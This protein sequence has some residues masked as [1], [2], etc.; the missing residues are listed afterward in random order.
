MGR[1]TRCQRNLI[2]GKRKAP[3]EHSLKIGETYIVRGLLWY[4]VGRLAAVTAR[5]IL[6]TEVAL[7]FDAGNWF[8]ALH[9][10]RLDE[11][12]AHPEACKV[13]IP[14]ATICDS[15]IWPY[16]LPEPGHRGPFT[17]VPLF[18]VEGK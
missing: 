12:A 17:G 10:G 15:T 6:L 2:A 3:E 4:F 5:D 14:W 11:V 1:I 9:E 7:V 18:T 13:S 16:T 8:E